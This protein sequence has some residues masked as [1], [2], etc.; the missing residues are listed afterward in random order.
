MAMMAASTNHRRTSMKTY[1]KA[2][3][4]AMMAFGLA[5]CSST[6]SDGM[7]GSSSSGSQGWGSSST[8]TNSNNGGSDNSN[9]SGGSGTTDNR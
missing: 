8:G 1:Q 5:A 4:G 9:A 2:L 6:N 7:S 3:I